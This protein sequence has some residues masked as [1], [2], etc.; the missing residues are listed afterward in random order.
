MATIPTPACEHKSC[1]H[2]TRASLSAN[3]DSN[4]REEYLADEQHAAALA[5]GGFVCRFYM[6]RLLKFSNFMFAKK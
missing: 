5:K 6:P 1:Q 2:E 4:R 3:A